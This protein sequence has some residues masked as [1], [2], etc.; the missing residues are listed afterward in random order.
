[1]GEGRNL[2]FALSTDASNKG[3][4]KLF[5]IAVRFYDVNGA[6]ITDALIDFYEQ[7]DETSGG[8]CELLATS[9]EKN[10][11]SWARP[12]PFKNA[13]VKPER[14]GPWSAVWPVPVQ[15]SAW[16]ANGSPLCYDWADIAP[17][18]RATELAQLHSYCWGATRIKRPEKPS[19]ARFGI[20]EAMPAMRAPLVSEVP[21][22]AP[23]VH[24]VAVARVTADSQR[25][26][27]L[28]LECDI[29][30]SHMDCLHCEFCEQL[31]CQER[32]S[33]GFLSRLGLQDQRERWMRRVHRVK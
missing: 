8:I 16:D 4:R 32:G 2:S 6:G 1:M 5:S 11:V 18:R 17:S 26:H 12:G 9:L 22:H 20:S 31:P 27:C 30:M 15:I 24:G 25:E 29:A 33:T 7:A 14:A 3:N 13:A 23:C 10:F 21:K 28:R 19:R